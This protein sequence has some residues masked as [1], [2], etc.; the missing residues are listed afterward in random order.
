MGAQ[1]EHLI[2]MANQIADNFQFS[3]NQEQQ[4]AAVADHMNRFWAASMKKDIAG[5]IAE[6]GEGLQPVVIAAAKR[7]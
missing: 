3:E 7:L 5:H 4:I 2:K 1:L 6:G